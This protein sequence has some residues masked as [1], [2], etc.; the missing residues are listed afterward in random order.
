MPKNKTRKKPAR[1]REQAEL[2]L[3]LASEDEGD[4]FLRN[5]G[6]FFE[7]PHGVLSH[8]IEL[9]KSPL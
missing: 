5:V 9:F 8:K 2:G 1:S 7:V 3:F 4:M 6:L